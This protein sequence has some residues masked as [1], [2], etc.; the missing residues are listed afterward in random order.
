MKKLFRILLS[1]A[2]VL[3]LVPFAAFGAGRD[4][5][6]WTFAQNNLD[7]WTA[8]K[9]E[10]ERQF[11]I[12]LHL[13]LVAQNA[14]V[15]K[16]QA[17]MMD[18]KDVPD[19]IEW[20]IEDN[21]VLSADPN[22][23]FVIPLEQWTSKSAAFKQLLP[24]RVAWMKYGSHQYGLPHDA[25]PVVLIYNDTLWKSVGV[26]VSKLATWDDFF[27]AAK[28]LTAE[29]EGGKPVH[30][31]LPYGHGGLGDT[32]WMIWEQTGAQILTP[33]GTPQFTSPAFKA[34]VMKWLSW[35]DTGVFTQWDWGN[36][37][38][39]LQSGTLASYTSPDWWVS[40]V[41]TAAKEGKYTFKVTKMPAY[42][43]GGVQS[44][45]WGGT[46]MAIPKGTKD[47]AFIYKMIEYMQTNLAGLKVRFQTSFMLPPFASLWSDPVFQSPDPRFGGQKLAALQVQVARQM[48]VITTGDVFWDAWRE[49][50]QV[51]TEI[52]TGKVS[53]DEG[54]QRAQEAT[55][56]LVE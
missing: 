22:K 45:S 48:P 56:K 11:G 20:L 2:L 47:P 34:F 33:D 53:V 14:F 27:V 35:I 50:N 42:S 41:N 51:Y 40:Q 8:R 38:A 46:F 28:K 19:I 37:G 13:E 30:Y 5:V 7:E 12:T 43:R 15:Q 29:Q 10:I 26:D 44:A 24:G 17:V 21:R 55:L 4:V 9:A 25:H 36:F 6:F 1:A 39:L 54:L 31:A 49:F 16:L 32:M 52:E 18:Q 3:T 23:S